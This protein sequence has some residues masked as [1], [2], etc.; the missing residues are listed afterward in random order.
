MSDE[1]YDVIIVGAGPAGLAAA[2]YTAR[3]RL[4][5]LLLE[6]MMPGGQINNTDRIE[7]YP[8]IVR[9]DGPG[10]IA[11]MQKQVETFGAKIQNGA[12]VSGL[13]KLED[14]NIGVFCGETQYTARS[15]ILAPG[16]TT[17]TWAFPVRRSS[18]G[19]V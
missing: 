19:R 18:R 10:L 17:G 3:D 2:V 6:R 11:E 13:E 14:S 8:G 16:A 1:V 5:T 4:N 12:N 9:I 15:V 7:N